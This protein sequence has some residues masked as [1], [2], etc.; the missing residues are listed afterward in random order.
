MDLIHELGAHVSEV[1]VLFEIE[2]LS[3]RTRIEEKFPN[4]TIRS[5]VKS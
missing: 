3:G 2:G 4:V 1:V 5:L